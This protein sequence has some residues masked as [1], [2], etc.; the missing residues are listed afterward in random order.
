MVFGYLLVVGLLAPHP[1]CVNI[2][3]APPAAAAAVETRTNAGIPRYIP[4]R[5]SECII[6][7]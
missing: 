2:E 5:T 1:S 4:V 6:R 3:V 7:H